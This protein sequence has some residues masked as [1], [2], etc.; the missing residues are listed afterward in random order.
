MRRGVNK[1]GI[2]VSFMTMSWDI[3][4]NYLFLLYCEKVGGKMS[5]M[6]LEVHGACGRYSWSLLISELDVGIA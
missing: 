5:Y 4:L 2:F 6:T 1:A 3:L